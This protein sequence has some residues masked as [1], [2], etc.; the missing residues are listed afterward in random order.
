M[1]KQP[2]PAANGSTRKSRILIIDDHPVVREGLTRIIEREPDLSICGEMGAE[3][4]PLNVVEREKP[5]LVLLGLNIGESDALDLVKRLRA[6]SARVRVLVISMY[7][8]TRYAERSI[9]A[10][11]SGYV[12][13]TEPAICVMC[14][15]RRILA[16]EIYVSASMS[17]IL[18]S[19]RLVEM[20]SNTLGS[21]RGRLTDRE[22]HVFQMIGSGI[23]TR[24]IAETMGLSIKTVESH[25]EHIKQKLSLH[26]G[27]ELMELAGKWVRD[28]HEPEE[29]QA[30]RHAFAARAAK[31]PVPT[32]GSQK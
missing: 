6:R 26:N 11:A 15:I 13:K 3:G 31:F 7:D 29:P 25:R 21:D 22:M 30:K 19:N 1:K 12:M 4:K 32:H 16:G 18:L 9:R 2:A 5:E 8:E 27:S 17:A 20:R 14:A 28:G 10:G 24:K 23:G